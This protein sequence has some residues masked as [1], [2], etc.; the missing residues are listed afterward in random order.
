MSKPRIDKQIFNILKNTD[1]PDYTGYFITEVGK[2][3]IEYIFSKGTANLIVFLSAL[4]PNSGKRF[5]RWSYANTVD[6]SILCLMDPMFEITG[7]KTWGYYYGTKEI[8]YRKNIAELIKKI[9]KKNDIQLCNTIIVGDSNAGTAAIF[10]HR[11]LPETGC[12]V[13]NPQLKRTKYS[14]HLEKTLGFE[15]DD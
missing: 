2:A 7:D 5:Q 11:L 8:D 6:C 9:A 15:L 4:Y 14:N 13:I 1:D 10:V 3:K 12:I